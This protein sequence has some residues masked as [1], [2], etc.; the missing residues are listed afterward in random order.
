MYV[1]S[2]NSDNSV[3]MSRFDCLYQYVPGRFLPIFGSEYN[4]ILHDLILKNLPRILSSTY[5]NSTNSTGQ[6]SKSKI[7]LHGRG[8]KMPYKNST[9]PTGLYFEIENR[10]IW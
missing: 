7:I 6:F 3:L 5:N 9:K 4:F 1:P 2:F 8:I 10:S